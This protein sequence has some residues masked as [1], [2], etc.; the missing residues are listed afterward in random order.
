MTIDVISSLTD[1]M[2][3]RP[4]RSTREAIGAYRVPIDDIIVIFGGWGDVNGGAPL[5]RK[6]VTGTTQLWERLEAL[7]PTPLHRMHI[8]AWNGSLRDSTGVDNAFRF[9]R[10]HFHPLGRLIVCGY[11]TGGFDAMRLTSHISMANRF[12]EVRSNTFV[13]EIY[14]MPQPGA[15]VF[16]FVRVDLMVTVDAAS[17]PTSGISFRRVF[18]S[19]RRNLNYYQSTGS[20]VGSHGGASVA[21][22]ANATDVV[23]LDMSRRYAANPAAGHGQIDNDTIDYVVEA[24]EI[25]LGRE[26]PPQ[27]F[28]AGFAAG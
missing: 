22:D 10:Q 13:R 18:P 24:V 15:E 16:G 14:R 11:S 2:T 1:R 6:P 17:G 19:V 9:I 21:M 3:R 26:A 4:T 23:N 12:Y 7:S 28:P 8:G 5:Q 27:L 20:S 25:V